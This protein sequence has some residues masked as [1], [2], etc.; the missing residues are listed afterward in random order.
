[1]AHYCHHS[2]S[3]SLFL[4]CSLCVLVTTARAACVSQGAVSVG[5]VLQQPEQ[6]DALAGES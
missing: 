2:A 4:L 6:G 3:P 1:M 5:V